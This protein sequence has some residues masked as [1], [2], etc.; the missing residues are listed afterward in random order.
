MQLV[1][2]LTIAETILSL[3]NDMAGGDVYFDELEG[4]FASVKLGVLSTSTK[5]S[6][7]TT[8]GNPFTQQQQSSYSIV[9]SL[10]MKRNAKTIIVL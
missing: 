5:G 7:T 6:F 10:Q 1:T 3:E 2:L 4:C 9:S 8:A